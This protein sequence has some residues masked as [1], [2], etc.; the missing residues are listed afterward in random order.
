MV[1]NHQCS[2]PGCKSGGRQKDKS[3]HRIPAD[4]QLKYRWISACL[5]EEVHPS[6]RVCSDHFAENDYNITAN[7]RKMLR[8]QA[9]PTVY[10]PEPEP[11]IVTLEPDR[12]AN[13]GTAC[14]CLEVC[15]CVTVQAEP[16]KECQVEDNPVESP[17]A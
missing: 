16:A 5:L 2:V 1:N 9:V 7:G 15:G 6:S 3:F 12:V 11:I 13:P 8:K 10:L 14:P 4:K 17:K